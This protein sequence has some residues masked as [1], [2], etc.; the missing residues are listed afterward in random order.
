MTGGNFMSNAT[1]RAIGHVDAELVVELA[2]GLC[3]RPSPRPHEKAA[4]VYLAEQ[5]DRLGFDVEL[6]DVV[7]DRPNVVAILRGDPDFQSCMLNGH[8]DHADP[9]GQW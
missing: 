2:R 5:L 1:T 6:Q 7:E 3:R 4:A 9:F 8:V